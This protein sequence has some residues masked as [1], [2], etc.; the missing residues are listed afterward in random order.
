MLVNSGS[1]PDSALHAGV[2]PPQN[3]LTELYMQDLAFPVSLPLPL[4]LYLP[5]SFPPSPYHYLY[6]Y[7][8]PSLP[9]P[10]LSLSLPSLSLC[11][12]DCVTSSYIPVKSF[13]N[14][15]KANILFEVEEFVP[16]IAKCSQPFTTYNNHL[17]VYPRQ[18]K[19]DGQKAFAKVRRTTVLM[20]K[21]IVIELL[22]NRT[23]TVPRVIY[24]CFSSSDK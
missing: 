1:W 15:E 5:L 21:C 12:S 16:S 11:V 23:L 19:Y 6:V 2:F 13:D 22:Y 10:Y 17:Y 4:S 8:T 18:L 14:G 7:L 3:V 9:L 20:T 24:F